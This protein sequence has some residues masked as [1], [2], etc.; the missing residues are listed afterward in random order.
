MPD[1]NRTQAIWEPPETLSRE[2]L[3]AASDAVLSRPDIPFSEQEQIF[4]VTSLGLDWDIG[5]VVYQPEDAAR[6]E[7]GRMR[8]ATPSPKRRIT[9]LVRKSCTNMETQFVKAKTEAKCWR[10]AASSSTKC[11]MLV[12]NW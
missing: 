4:R 6:I 12:V 5:V 10:C 2:E 9:K 7:N 3:V 8:S 11:T 1:D